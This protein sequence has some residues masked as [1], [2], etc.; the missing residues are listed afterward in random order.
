MTDDSINTSELTEDTGQG[1]GPF[2]VRGR[3]TW[4]EGSPA[5]GVIVRAYD[6]DLRD[7]QP[8][9]PFAPDFT[10]ETRT[11]AEGEY[12]IEYDRAEFE[13]AEMASADLIVRV[14]D[15]AHHVVAASPT[16][17]NA[18]RQATVDLSVSGAVA[19]LPSEFE[20]LVDR[21][22][23]LLL[24][25][26]PP[27]VDALV[28]SD[29]A[30]VVGVTGWPSGL[31]NDLLSAAGLANDARGAPATQTGAQGTNG[32][33]SSTPGAG[34]TRTVDEIPVGAL[35]GL[36]REG[37]AASWGALQQAGPAV[38]TA[39]LQ[40]AAT[41]G[42]IPAALGAE[43]AA[44]GAAVVQVAGQKVL[45]AT[46]SSGSPGL[47]GL[48]GAASLSGAQQQTLLSVVSGSDA[49]P[50][51][52]W[53]DLAASL[54]FDATSVSRLQLTLQLGLLTGNHL[55]LVEHLL[56]D[57]SITSP[58]DLVATGQAAWVQALTADVGGQPVG[59]PS[60]VPG[61]TPAEQ[62]ANYASALVSTLQAA[63]PNETVAHLVASDATLVTDST[64]RTGVG[65]FFANAPSF[66][67]RTDRI[68]TYV[69]AN[70]GSLNGV[71]TAD[72]P[73]VVTELKRLQRA[74]QI[75]V[76]A[77]SMSALL[78]EGLDAAHKVADI[79]HQTFL[80]RYSG[81][82]GGTDA[83][84]AVYSR[85]GF[86]NARSL[87]V[88]ANLNE[89]VNGVWPQGL[90]GG[91]YGN[92]SGVAKAQI[93]E[94]YP[95]YAELFGALDPCGCEECMSVLSPAAY[96]VDLLQFLANSAPNAAG[97]TPLDVLIGKSGSSLPGR[98]PD[99]A[100]LKLTCENTNT[101]LPYID[102][103]NEVLEA[104]ILYNG[105]NTA[106][107][108]DTGSTTT[109][110][111]DANP[112]YTLDAQQY[113]LS[114]PSTTETPGPYFT[115]AGA[116][117]PF[118]LPFH[119]P[120]EVARTYVN[121][122][123][124]SRAKVLETFQTDPT[125]A[126]AA[127][128]AE[129]LG[130]DPYLYELLTGQ[131]VQGQAVAAPNAPVLYG[132][133]SPDPGWETTV[134]SVPTFLTRTGIEVTDLT[135]LLVTTFV[136]PAYPAGP[137]L[138]FFMSIPLSYS[139]LMTLVGAGFTTTD[140][141][142]LGELADAGI[143][144]TQL[145]EWWARNPDIGQVLVIESPGGSCDLTDATLGHLAD[146]SAPTDAELERLQ[147][148]IRLWRTVGWSI[149]GL[150]RAF[151]AFAAT[152]IT[153]AFVHDLARTTQ[154]QTTLNG[155]DLQCVFALWADLDPTGAD[156]LY[157]QLFL[158]PA[159]LPI[160]PAFEPG[161]NGA[162]LSD[163]S[164]LV[165]A[166][167]PALVA[168]L[169][170]SADDLDLIGVD[171]G[172]GSSAPLSLANVST[173]Y[174][175]ATLATQLGLSVSDFITLRNL[176]GPTLDPFV[177]PDQAVDF[178]TLAQNLSNSAFT[179]SQL[180]YLYEHRS[181]PPTGLAPQ[182]TTLLVLAQTMRAGLTQIATQC[183][184]QPD[185]KGTLTATTVTQLVSKAV[186]TET[187]ALVNG[188]ALY[189]APLATLPAA[190]A[191]LD[192][193]ANVLGVDPTKTPPEVGAKLTYDPADG[194]FGYVGAMT[195][196]E[197]TDLDAVSN[198]PTYR[199]AI[200][201]LFAQPATF[202]ADNLGPLLDDPAAVTTLLRNTASLDGS[203]NPVLLD[204]GGNPVAD[205]TLAA[206]T[207]IATRFA[208][209]L[210]KLLPYLQNLLSHTLVKQTV[211]DALSLDPTLTSLLLES[212]LASPTTSS[213][214]VI[215]DL[216]ALGT[217][218][219]TAS[220][221]PTADLSGPATATVDLPAIDFTGGTTATSLPSGTGSA[222]F[223][224]WLAVPASG[225]F[226]FR[227]TTDG[228]PTLFVGD[229]TTSLTL[230]PD[231][232]TGVPTATVALTAG[233]LTPIRLQISSLPAGPGTALLTW[234]SP[235]TPN[236]PVPTAA[237]LPDGVVQAF[238]LAYVRVQ[239]AALLANLLG[240]GAPEVQYLAAAGKT[241][242]FAGFDLDALPLT[243]GTTTP[244][245]ATALFA[246]WQRLD[247][248]TALRSSLPAGSV[249]LVDVF[250]AP[251][252]GAASA[253]VPQ[254]TGWAPA[255]ATAL[256]DTFFP[257]L[258]PTSPNPLND[259]VTLTRLQACVAL[260][261]QVGASPAQLF[262][263]AAFA[264]PTPETSFTGLQAIAT[265]IKK[266][267]ASHYTPEAWLAT[268]EPLSDTVRAAQRD[269][270][271]AYLLGLLGWTD[272]DRL[273]ELLLID[274]EMGTCMQTSRIRQALNSVQL[275]VQRCLL[276]LEAGGSAAS[277][278]EPGQIDNTTWQDWMGAFSMW[279]SNRE[280]FLWP[281][282]WLLPALRDDQ[283]P[284]FEAFAS[285]LQ[286]GAITNASVATTF[287]AY[288]QGLEQVDRLDIRALF[289]QPPDPS[290]PGST[291][292]LHVFGR[293]FHDPRQYF[294]RRQ[295]GG[296]SWTPWEEV[297][298]D[299]QGDHLVAAQW[300]G[301][302]RLIWPIF[303]R[304]SYAPPQ[305]GNLTSGKG[306]NQTPNPGPPPMDYWQIT[307]A[308]TEYYEGAW[309]PKS[310]TEDFMV[311]YFSRIWNPEQGVN[312]L[313]EPSESHVFKARI[314][315]AD[316]VIE[317]YVDLPDS[318]EEGVTG[319]ANH[320]VPLLLGEFRFSACG[321]SVAVS[322]DLWV[323]GLKTVM[324]N[325]V[326]R[327]VP[328]LPDGIAES[329]HQTYNDTGTAA[330]MLVPGTDPYNDGFRQQREAAPKLTMRTGDFG[331]NT[332]EI[333]GPEPAN[334][335]ITFLSD[336]PTRF[337]VRCAQDN[338]QFALQ[339]PFFYQDA[340]RTFCVTPSQGY[341]LSDQLR[342]PVRID[343]RNV[344]TSTLEIPTAVP[345]GVAVQAGLATQNPA[346]P[347]ANAVPSDPAATGA[348][349][350]AV[351]QVLGRA[352]DSTAARL[353]TAGSTTDALTTAGSTALLA[354]VDPGA[355]PSAAASLEVTGPGYLS[356]QAANA[357][358]W[359]TATLPGWGYRMPPTTTLLTFQTHRHPYVCTLIQDLVAAENR[360]TDHTGGIDGL[361]NV[362][363]Q[364]PPT[365]FHF[366]GTYQPTS[367]VAKPYPT[368]TID[369]SPTGAYSDYNWELFFHVPLLVALTL[370]QN[371]QF[372]EADRWF[373]YIFDP[374]NSDTTTASPERYWQV[375]PFR[376]AAPQTLLD[377]M[378]AIDAGD[379]D[380]VAQVKDWYHNPFE[381][382][383]VARSRIGAFQK[384]VFMAY[385]DNLIAWGDQLFG[386]VDTI[387][388]INQATQLYV[389]A[390]ELLGTLPEELPAPESP[391]ELSYSQIRSKLDAFS[392]FSEMLENEFPFAGG[393]SGGG[394]SGGLLGLSKL[395]F[396]CI[397]QNQQLLGYWAT[398]AD[399]LYKIRHCLNIHG[400]PQQLALFQ[401][402]INPLLLIEAAAEGIDLG[403]V[404]A[405]LAAPL[406]NYRHSF[407]IAKAAELTA[408]CQSFGHSLLDALE[409]NDAEGLVLLR[410]T[411]ET[412]ILKL[413]HDQKVAQV[414]EAQ[415]AV[416]AFYGSRA[417]A[418]SKYNY[419]Q[420]LIGG[421]GPTSPAVGASIPL[422]SIP[423]ETT[424]STGGV[425]LLNEEATEL[426]LST[427]SAL[428]HVGAGVLQTLA[429]M[430]ATIPS[431]SIGIDAQP[432][433]V[434]GNVSVSFGGSN[435]S[436]STEAVVHGIET[437]AAYLTYQ[438][439]SAGK[440]GG[441]VRRQQEWTFQ[442]N[443]AAGEIMQ[444]DQ[445]IAAAGTRVT[446]AQD[447]L[448]VNETQTTNSQAVETYLTSKFTNQQL[449]G[450]M[451]NQ[452][453]S[454][455]AQLYQLAYS[456]AQQAEVAYQR[457]L[458]VP[459]SSYITFGYWDSLRKGLLAG[460]RLQLAVKQLERAYQDQNE[461]E[462]ELT[463]H[464][465]LLLHDPAALMALKTTG[466]CVV[467]LPEQLFDMDYPGHYLR[468]LRDVS[469]TIPCVAGPYTSV[470]CTLT[471]VSS[472]VRSD[473]GTGTSG[474][475]GYAEKKGGDP[476]FIYY[477]GSTAAIATSHAQDDSGVFSVNFRDE[478]Y[479]PFE[480][481]G[482]VSRWMLT[483][484][485]VTNAID[486]D[487]I[488][489]V[490]MKLSYTS[491]YGGDL[492][493][494][495]AFASATLPA[496]PVQTA[497]PA[498][499]AA[500]KQTARDRLFSVKH[501]FPTGWYG[502]LHPTGTTAT[503]GQMPLVLSSDRFPYLYRGRTLKTTDIEVFAL[504]GSGATITSLDAYLTPA[505][506]PPP[507]GTP[508]VPPAPNTGTDH[509]ALAAQAL[510]GTTTLYG[511]KSEST[512]VAVPQLWWLSLPVA[513]LAEVIAQVEDF[514][515]LVHYNVS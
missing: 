446:I 501:E 397:P 323:Q 95:D 254:A 460:D 119:Q 112:Q 225:T 398:V 163:L 60:G 235:T 383:R 403:S 325:G 505:G 111:L 360:L 377:L 307:L 256:L 493:R 85:A 361:L 135:A 345:P 401:P 380:A 316:L 83:A 374:T 333:F 372:Q 271:V 327:W 300:E 31:V 67:L 154:L 206:S 94:A 228:T 117:F 476:R 276:N 20:R 487:T 469:L 71:A 186:A 226:T 413:I 208:Y 406:P 202:V 227:V 439:W 17:F 10:E 479:L 488:T 88:M 267:T 74:F 463:R 480:T 198:D 464:V 371:Q 418:V 22:A 486:F 110:A 435:L 386:Q 402:P 355:A 289:W 275:F 288:L 123:G 425:Q 213:Q 197:Q 500:P 298:A 281:E 77:D 36:L 133:P 109:A 514:F 396:F 32:Q 217:A 150:D 340:G 15:A 242:L 216:L 272:P 509:V 352:G 55:P 412:A 343:I 69:A 180:A 204:S 284:L 370:S 87:S 238:T 437:A 278:V 153:P 490:V 429:A 42:V 181:A 459:D 483:M 9:G 448:K 283:T 64:A 496:L 127:V 40:A 231:L 126:A 105:P 236:A 184:V 118:T 513:Q 26:E 164:V 335:K 508:P 86:I 470:N 341:R 444:I 102:L 376:T 120:I 168:A 161:T 405:N 205:P 68:S 157:A 472:K 210:S 503:Y 246:G 171:A 27:T 103:V 79:P 266:A 223:A 363:N 477:S 332:W 295:L 365:T 108:H 306:S 21:I 339:S 438:A 5:I 222:T 314:D 237:L 350:G 144:T 378:Q 389:F 346:L 420:L 44:L 14:L 348:A 100:Y 192:G 273:F 331:D 41:A 292:V 416:T 212:V 367:Y 54:G 265:D 362:A 382:F 199:A 253:L 175:Y 176:A 211:A 234:Q 132:Y 106:A 285:S 342:D 455:Y 499:G 489:D 203:L 264:W 338:W 46:G 467:E 178:A 344:L 373:R 12:A 167:S 138:E 207:A 37:L 379:A 247:A 304:Q 351:P 391:T 7:D 166:H 29:Q 28:P 502:M 196:Q 290:T 462:F 395:L 16:L 58:K 18:P 70:A 131:N 450:W 330:V 229:L 428:L 30:F 399:R 310:V 400:V 124:T 319:G 122:L 96:F 291:D 249:T 140:P 194:T 262:S 504:L 243:A 452:V 90:T 286:Q 366:P 261:L 250:A 75:S 322:Y 170:V 301:R 385:L 189:S 57:G 329:P 3:V 6:Q 320:G 50:E 76:G 80:D 268:A 49:A 48:L 354:G 177:S 498:I 303:T 494:S 38:L 193:A 359:A 447:D 388:S 384:N 65:Q 245:Q 1:D 282:N 72:Q 89:T 356:F 224:S 125:A 424:Q 415:Q 511:L 328:A 141:T 116:V 251:S 440:M 353:T 24:D 82:L 35:Y 182:Q 410:A 56:A 81:A 451:V 174:R 248:Y 497:A 297:Q 233:T 104:Y 195:T 263:W 471:L 465:S 358:N 113:E 149:P 114:P 93:L 130:L 417:V 419:Y 73:T 411:Q 53:S 220:W 296:Q 302:L 173:L 115:L 151:K 258:T 52:M 240:L 241:G 244:A 239:K 347:A 84:E 215:S 349:A 458:G 408:S 159:S 147:A 334:H 156:S 160:D 390:S 423:T 492:L 326:A 190:L 313:A 468:R 232:T 311:S 475:S 414:T 466:E 139:A 484:P 512:S 146:A 507:S 280:V 474:S 394:A 269:A 162:V 221:Y 299:I 209:L 191:L 404:L 473:P 152:G 62:Q 279:A 61:A 34:G 137:D 441:Y 337:E 134:A 129:Q 219:V 457:E 78:L 98:R 318:T 482:V 39:D 456:T 453:S 179:A 461:R 188:T 454:L 506:T 336:T 11:D 187:V 260:I 255:V 433:G 51:Q 169:Q 317:I 128:D 107:A 495:Q 201:S 293:T 381:P 2:V 392:N 305:S 478:R 63:F 172:I 287:L 4:P 312:P 142:V 99:L 183:T 259:E 309:Q 185:P 218:G 59:V 422:V 148:F 136:N 230:T 481:A 45:T 324:I 47:S 449:Y 8:L 33:S 421:N 277:V 294:Y 443:L 214:P 321:D 155:P 369:F 101:E 431:V 308:W 357:Q 19:G 430:E 25:L 252:F 407:L 257:A 432:F 274:P 393:I 364:N 97:N 515:V 375:Q 368:E 434:G 270:L 427:Q 66:D 445:Q 121:F 158:N 13:A 491:R 442:N 91:A 145:S 23:P 143:T 426:G 315:G 165:S 510:Y 200:A 436:S 409:K 43:A 92:G 387:E 485:K